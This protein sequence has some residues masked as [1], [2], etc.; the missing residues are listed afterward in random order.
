MI[1]AKKYGVVPVADRPFFFVANPK[2]FFDFSEK[3]CEKS[4]FKLNYLNK[5]NGN[6][7]V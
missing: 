2:T 3:K 7:S 6:V 5:V 1:M 4:H